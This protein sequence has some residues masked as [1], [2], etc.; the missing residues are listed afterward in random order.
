MIL[1]SSWI[2]FLSW[3][4]F[5][6][7]LF[8]YFFL[9]VCVCACFAFMQICSQ[10]V[11]LVDIEAR[12]YKISLSWGCCSLWAAQCQYCKLILSPLQEQQ[13]ILTTEPF[14][15]LQLNFLNCKLLR[16]FINNAALLCILCVLKWTYY[17]ACS[18]I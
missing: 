8:I 7:L 9:C 4:R 3:T 5:W 17:T 11:Y 12:S 1:L 15:R 16:L 18:N 2:I 13:M 6:S 10:W 14:L